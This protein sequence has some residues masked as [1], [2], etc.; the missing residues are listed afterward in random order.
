M[1]SRPY[2]NICG[3]LERVKLKEDERKG[4][5]RKI[6]IDWEMYRK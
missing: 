5:V 4:E 6:I 1:S 2:W 3:R